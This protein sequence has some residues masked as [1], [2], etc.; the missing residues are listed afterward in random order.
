MGMRI[1][2]TLL[3]AVGALT[4]LPAHAGLLDGYAVTMTW[5]YPD[6]T[7]QYW[8]PQTAVVGA[9]IEFPLPYNW[10]ID[11]SGNNVTIW[12][13]GPGGPT[14]SAL[15]NGPVL[16]DANGTIP[17]FTGVTVLSST[18]PGWDNS[19]AYLIDEN[20]LAVNLQ[21]LGSWTSSASLSLDLES[22]VPEPGAFL[23]LA[24][25]LGILA[26]GCRR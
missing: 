13:A 12:N 18:F 4:V 25:G 15:I 6:L 11:L 23:L 20:T 1:Q 24:T 17:A 21:G 16:T 3:A 2:M 14:S 26:C 9:G 19:R 10:Y 8:A 7:T 5:Y 22:A